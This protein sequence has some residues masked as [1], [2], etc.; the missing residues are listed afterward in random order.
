MWSI[1]FQVAGLQG[2]Y[3]VV[4]VSLPPELSSRAVAK[5]HD[6]L[7][8]GQCLRTYRTQQYTRPFFYHEHLFW[9][10]KHV[11]NKNIA[12]CF[13]AACRHKYFD[14]HSLHAVL[15]LFYSSGSVSSD[16][17]VWKPR[18]SLI[19]GV[20]RFFCGGGGY[21]GGGAPD[22]S[23]VKTCCQYRTSQ[24]TSL[25]RLKIKNFGILVCLKTFFC[26][27]GAEGVGW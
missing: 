17:D 23:R 8:Q 9:F 18:K 3:E 14:K 1:Y 13:V 4:A 21:M 27:P 15:Q 11:D 24:A 19:S 10:E 25:L 16:K 26:L 7:L 5:L 12:P 22:L 6:L 20:L 2:P